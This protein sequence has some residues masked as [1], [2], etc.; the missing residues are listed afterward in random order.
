VLLLLLVLVLLVLLLLA[1]VCL[2][3]HGRNSNVIE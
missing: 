2:R 1:R 3:F